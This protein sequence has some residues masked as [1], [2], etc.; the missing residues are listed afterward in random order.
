MTRIARRRVINPIAREVGDVAQWR[1]GGGG[2][3]AGTWPEASGEADAPGACS[4]PEAADAAGAGIQP[5]AGGEADAAGADNR[6]DAGGPRQ[7]V[8]S[9]LA[10]PTAGGGATVRG[11]YGGG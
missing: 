3:V 9:E 2:R 5:E 10:G 7:A 1:R 11:D 4:R 6:P 8:R